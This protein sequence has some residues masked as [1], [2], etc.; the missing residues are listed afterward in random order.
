[1]S[2]YF[3]YYSSYCGIPRIKILGT[4]QDWETLEHKVHRMRTEIFKQD[5]TSAVQKMNEYLQRVETQVHKIHTTRD[6][7]FWQGMFSINKCMSGHSDAVEG[8]IVLLY[9]EGSTSVDIEFEDEEDAGES[10]V[11]L[12]GNDFYNYKSHI[13][14]VKWTHLETQRHF[15]LKSGLLYSTVVSGESEDDKK[16]PWL[17]PQFC[18]VTVETDGSDA[19]MTHV[20]FKKYIEETLKG[21]DK[22]LMRA[23]YDI[24]KDAPMELVKGGSKEVDFRFELVGRQIDAWKEDFLKNGRALTNFDLNEGPVS[25]A[26]DFYTKIGKK[27]LSASNTLQEKII[28]YLTINTNITHIGLH[29]KASR[30][31]PNILDA[32]IGNPNIEELTV[33]PTTQ[34][35]IDKL[36]EL[37]LHSACKLRHIEVLTDQIGSFQDEDNED[38]MNTQ[39]NFKILA[40]ALVKSSAPM[41][42][43][44]FDNIGP[45]ELA[46]AVAELCQRPDGL[47]NLQIGGERRMPQKVKEILLRGQLLSKT[48]H[49]ISVPELGRFSDEVTDLIVKNLPLNSSLETIRNFSCSMKAADRAK[50]L[51][52]PSLKQIC[53]V[54][55]QDLSFLEV[56]TK[57]TNI[58][59]TINCTAEH[60]QR[61]HDFVSRD[62]CA[63]EELL[64][65]R[66]TFPTRAG[67][68]LAKGLVL[69]KSIKKLTCSHA[70][71][72]SA[73]EVY[74]FAELI[75]EWL[76]KP[77]CRLEELHL[78]EVS[79]VSK[80][81]KTLQRT[82]NTISP[83]KDATFDRLMINMARN[84]TLKKV[85]VDVECFAADLP[86]F[87]KLVH[88]NTVLEEIYF[89]SS[90]NTEFSAQNR[91]QLVE[92]LKK[93][94]TLV[95]FHAYFLDHSEQKYPAIPEEELFH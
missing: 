34:Q 80:D 26:F 88:N 65:P 84:S 79:L 36:S 71:F 35:S 24:I 95:Q 55:L 29:K 48:L 67:V 74:E 70:T 19:K 18:H 50:A 62:D 90:S 8:W 60:M 83:F 25:L 44:K 30:M 76:K 85:F 87:T 93:N 61:L 49:S 57:L 73:E 7:K 27:N 9:R 40:D 52:I 1:M 42:S 33:W 82:S 64:I 21:E 58:S 75:V 4:K 15:E 46:N 10:V 6:P 77:Y 78:R 5:D 16:Y 20:T 28:D 12:T 86:L 72:G 47:Q 56:T 39:L 45:E 38:S 81:T 89:G 14:T 51:R 91:A 11:E 59:A 32:L 53:H 3:Y 54:D 17:E 43:L 69:N 2:A 41:K 23:F 68:T 63:L 66:S 94:K 31:E 13:S 22:K 37:L 92:A